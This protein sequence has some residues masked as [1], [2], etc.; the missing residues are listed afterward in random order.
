MM[1]IVSRVASFCLL[2]ANAIASP[3]GEYSPYVGETFPRNVYW[4]DTHLHSS[5]SSDAF[6]L[7]VTLGPDEAFRFAAGQ[8]AFKRHAG[9]PRIGWGALRAC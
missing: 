3:A 1:K 7:G 2:L 9:F 6:G 5:L 4:G 8:T